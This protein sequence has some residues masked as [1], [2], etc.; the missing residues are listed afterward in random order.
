METLEQAEQI[1]ITQD[2]GIIPV[3]YYVTLNM[4]DTDEWG[5]WH[6]NVM[7]YH[8]VKDIYKK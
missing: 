4:I 8:P 5:G 2:Q 7:D 6:E 3:Y 1:F